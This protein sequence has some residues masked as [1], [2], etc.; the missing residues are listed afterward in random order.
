MIET[1]SLHI[2]S[3]NT[4]DI[5]LHT[6]KFNEIF[7][8]GAMSLGDCFVMNAI[9]HEYAKI[10]HK[11]V[12][13]C[14]PEYFQ[15]LQSLYQDCDNIQVVAFETTEQENAF[16]TQ[17]GLIK[18][19]SP[20]IEG[21]HIHRAGCEPE[22]IHIHWPQQIYENFDIVFS[23]RYSGF[24][25][26]KNI[27]GSQEL[28]ESMTDG[29]PY[30]LVHRYTGDHPNG[31]PIN[32]TGFRKSVGL[33]DLPII[34][35]REGQTDNMLQ[36]KTLIE[37]AAEVHCVPSSF[38]CLVDSMQLPASCTPYFHDIRRNSLM[39]VNSRWNNHKWHMVNYSVR[40]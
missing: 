26:P 8:C 2:S 15:T 28:Y 35:I 21:T 24:K 7:F 3:N 36:Y 34:E 37:N 38:F 13:P 19:F 12:Y 17:H 6:K 18:I 33:P 11:L 4:T 39:K 20:P 29:N 23:K 14:K 32:I 10:S 5:D 30:V 25:M 9:V 22:Y 40:I 1:S 27:A 31:I 16:I